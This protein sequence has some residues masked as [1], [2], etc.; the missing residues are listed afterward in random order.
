[1][2]VILIGYVPGGVVAPIPTLRLVLVEPPDGGVT[3]EE[4]RVHVALAGQPDRSRPT[5]ALNPFNEVTVTLPLEVPDWPAVSFSGEEVAEMA[6]SS[7][8]G[9]PQLLNLK[10][11]MNVLQL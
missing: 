3:E 5:A 10:D 2:P 11:P 6:K 7:V 1:M 9:R 4:P 8:G